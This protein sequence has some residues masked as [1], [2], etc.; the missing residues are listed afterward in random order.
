MLFIC[1]HNVALSQMAEW[2]LQARYCDRYEAA[3]AGIEPKGIHPLAV[4]GMVRLEVDISGQRPKHI[5]EFLV[6]EFDYVV[7]VCDHV[8]GLPPSSRGARSTCTM[9]S[10]TSRR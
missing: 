10:P 8:R 6:R 3:S 7:T 2:L 9:A 4:A 1:T 5:E